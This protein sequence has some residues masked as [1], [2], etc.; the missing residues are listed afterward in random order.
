MKAFTVAAAIVAVGLAVSTASARTPEEQS[1]KAW[2]SLK[3]VQSEKEYVALADSSTIAMACT[4][5]K[6]VSVIVKREVSTKPGHGTV[7][8]TLS[9]HQCPGCGGKMTTELK[10]TKMIHICT[11]CGDESAFCCATKK[12]EKTLGMEKK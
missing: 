3:P 9:V 2:L 6:S 4:K 12:G 5:C 10:Q 1:S 11:S 7:E 8:E